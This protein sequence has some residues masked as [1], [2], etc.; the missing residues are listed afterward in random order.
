MGMS[1]LPIP[2]KAG[3]SIYIFDEIFADIGDEQSIADSLSTFSSHITNIAFLLKNATQNSLV[4]VDEL[5]SGTDPIEGSSL[6]ISILEHLNKANILTIATTHYHEVKNY[7]LVTNHFENASVAFDLDTLSPTYKLLIGVPGRSNAF[8]ISQKLGICETIINR[9]KELINEDTGKL[10]DLL[11]SIYENTRIIEEEKSRIEATSREIE[12]LK[13]SYQTNSDELKRKEVE[14]LE[15]AKIKAREILLDAKEEANEIIKNLQKQPNA[16]K[17][18]DLRNELNQKIENL[19]I[20]K[21]DEK[22]LKAIEKSAVKIGMEVEIPSLGQIGT[23]LSDVTKNDTVQVQI[24]NMKTYF[25]IS[26]IVPTTKK[27]APQ[28]NIPSTKKHDFKVSRIS[29]E[30]N[31]IGQNVEEACFVV[32][33]YLDNCVL[34]GLTNARIVHGKGTGILKNGIHKFLKKHP[35]VKSFRLGTFGEGEDGVTV[36]ELK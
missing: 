25:K 3:S 4:L 1:G 11:N 23:I 16:K 5:G 34:N 22:S 7:A 19:S 20:K 14:I 13:S 32:D 33:K 24:G 2:A 35:H 30:I 6:A 26:E 17:S 15:N 27:S 29:P 8:V 28:K 18:N 12:L 21:K 10:E 36:V 9:A 31:V